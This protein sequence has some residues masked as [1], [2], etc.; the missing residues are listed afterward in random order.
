MSALSRRDFV[1]VVSTAAAAASLPASG[2]CERSE[3]EP[4]SATA[5]ARGAQAPAAADA[6]D[7][8]DRWRAKWTWDRAA[9]TSHFNN[10]AYQTHCLFEVYVKDG[11]LLREEQAATYPALHEGVPDPNPR[12]CQKGCAYSALEA[13]GSRV[14]QPLRRKG[15]RGS[16][17]WEAISW[18]VA[19]EEIADRL[20]SAIVESGPDSVVMDVGTNGIGTTAQ[21]AAQRLAEALDCVMLDP[22][23][24]IGDQQQGAAV[25]YG[26]DRHRALHREL[27]RLRPDPRLEREPRLHADP[28]LS[29]PHRGPLSRRDRRRDR[30]GLQ[31][32]GDARRPLRPGE[33][34]HRRRPRAGDGEVDPRRRAARRGAAARADRPADPRAG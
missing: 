2:G 13:G 14:L 27:L 34:R 7:Y 3:T 15:P 33:T 26:G 8:R 22:N 16:G 21:A 1:K 11:E 24:E 12:G 19:L 30:A 25:T 28:E 4:A 31:R 18:D 17:A 9:K 32:V 23:S 6:A 20:V 5:A 10:C 29:L